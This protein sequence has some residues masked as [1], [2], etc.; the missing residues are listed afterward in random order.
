MDDIKVSVIIPVY[1]VERYLVECLNSLIKQTLKDI[2]II[3]VDDGSTDNSLN[4]LNEYKKRDKRI[5]VLQ[6]KNLGAG[7]A[8]NLGLKVAKGKYLSFLDSDDFFEKDM[9]ELAYEQIEKD[10]SDVVI[11]AAKQYNDISKKTTEMPWSLRI[12]YLPKHNPFMPVEMEKYLFDSFQNWAWNKLFRQDF[13]KNEN[14]KFQEIKRTNDMAFV[15]LA[16]AAASKISII[17]KSFVYYRIATGISL[18]QTNDRSPLCFWEAYLETRN[19]LIHK[20]LYNKYQQSFLNTVL[21]GSLYNLNSVKS[22]KAYNS[23]YNIIANELNKEFSFNKFTEKYF[24]NKSH[25]QEFQKIQHK[26]CDEY[27]FEKLKY[28]KNLHNDFKNFQNNNQHQTS[29]TMYLKIKK[30]LKNYGV[31]YTLRKIIKKLITTQ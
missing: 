29:K 19:R 27:I 1:N 9:L 16:L 6:Q 26:Q 18:Q 10:K 22:Y 3:C 25:Y 11:F 21:R 2:E 31:N 12:E 23:I 13:I 30:S 20:G 7:V 8:R 17:K 15:C 14:I 24:H 28:Y 5:I 4:I